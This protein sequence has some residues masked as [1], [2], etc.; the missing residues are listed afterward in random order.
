MHTISIVIPTR[1]RPVLL[2]EALESIAHQSLRPMEIIIVDDGSA[3]PVDAHALASRFGPALRVVRNISS[4]GLAFS[5]N[6]GVEEA[7][8]DY[9][10][11]L[12]DDDLLD[13][14][15]I[16]TALAVLQRHPDL[17]LVFINA[18][19]FGPHAGHFN[20]VQPK[21]IKR[22]ISLGSGRRSSPDLVHFGPDLIKALLH[23]VPIAFQRIMVPRLKW[24][25]ISAFRR[26]AYRIDSSIPDDNAAQRAITGP[27]RDSE[28]SVY[29]AALCNSTALIV[30]P[31]YLQRCAG[32]GYSSKPENRALHMQQ[33]L[34]IKQ[35]LHRAARRLPELRRWKS[36]IRDSLA[37][38]Q[39]NSAYHH[40]QSGTR[41]DSWNE[42]LKALLLKPSIT[43]ARLA[44]RMWLPRSWSV[45]APPQQLERSA[46]KCSAIDKREPGRRP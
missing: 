45:N 7:Q 46:G 22:V 31:L 33:G 39:F 16:A 44:I 14:D 20:Q 10:I 8:G 43:Y 40:F 13:P 26:R 28:W 18:H 32:Q 29:A 9:V 42:L 24:H 5:R 4:Q 2:Q 6:R 37:S 21:A 36:E 23:S 30:R 41:N 17:D 27:L 19:G 15:A 1:D 11:H 34:L 38:A 3:Q 12:D 35:Q 25:S